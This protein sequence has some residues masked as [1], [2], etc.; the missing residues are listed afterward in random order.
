[1]IMVR[2]MSIALLMCAGLLLS[3]CATIFTGNTQAVSIQSE[4]SG[5]TVQVDGIQMGTTPCQVV[6]S[7]GSSQ[8]LQ[9]S[10]AGY[11]T[12][13]VV[14]GSKFN[15]WFLANLI[16]GG[17]IGMIVDIATGAI[18]WVDPESVMVRLATKR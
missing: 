7:R 9:V 18:V 15:G 12:K 8:S 2:R 11:E 14:L 13:T 10:K 6:L 16:F 17:I 5:A 1:M 3:G 4:P